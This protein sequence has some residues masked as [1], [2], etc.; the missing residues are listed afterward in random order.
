LRRKT[1]ER[2]VVFDRRREIEVT[3]TQDIP[4]SC[5]LKSQLK[6]QLP[7]LLDVP[8]SHS[9]SG[10]CHFFTESLSQEQRR[11]EILTG[12]AGDRKESTLLISHPLSRKVDNVDEGRRVLGMRKR[13]RRCIF[14]GDNE[15]RG[16]GS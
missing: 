16:K 4:R 2:D 10:S 12:K 7:F 14:A 13:G 3:H 6:S 8:S 9:F 5:S 11:L 1:G 15:I